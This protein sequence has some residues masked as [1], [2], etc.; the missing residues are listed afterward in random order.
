[1]EPLRSSL[2]GSHHSGLK[3]KQSQNDFP[4]FAFHRML[5]PFRPKWRKNGVLDEFQK[6][7]GEHIEVAAPFRRP[8]QHVPNHHAAARPLSDLLPHPLSRLSFFAD[9][10]K[11]CDT[12]DGTTAFASFPRKS[13]LSSPAATARRDGSCDLPLSNRLDRLPPL[14]ADWSAASPCLPASLRWFF[15]SAGLR[16]ASSPIRCFLLAA[17]VL[18]LAASSRGLPYPLPSLSR[19]LPARSL[20][21]RCGLSPCLFDQTSLVALSLAASVITVTVWFAFS[22]SGCGLSLSPLLFSL[23]LPVAASS[24][25]RAGLSCKS[26]LFVFVAALV[27][28]TTHCGLAFKPRGLVVQE[29]SRG[30]LV[31]P[32]GSPRSSGQRPCLS[33]HSATSFSYYRRLVAQRRSCSDVAPQFPRG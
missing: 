21:N 2:K 6:L 7:F 8:K 9:P 19:C 4:N 31:F 28:L 32:L 5:I 3:W 10:F 33:S 11:P 29:L 13:Y 12:L 18:L 14:P 16:P 24:I 30:D 22:H 23:R 15:S 1:M 27:A 17:R 20:F 26:S 25:N